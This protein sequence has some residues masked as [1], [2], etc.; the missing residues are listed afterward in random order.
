M[1]VG[2]VQAKNGAPDKLDKRDSPDGPDTVRAASTPTV[3]KATNAAAS[4]VCFGPA[5]RAASSTGKAPAPTPAPAA[6]VAK[7]S[8]TASTQVRPPRKRKSDQ[9]AT[10]TSNAVTTDASASVL[11]D[12]ALGRGAGTTEPAIAA[13]L[14]DSIEVQPSLQQAVPA[15]D[16]VIGHSYKSAA[17]RTGR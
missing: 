14:T 9:V 3:A 11:V 4:S 5:H 6:D 7:A 13:P 12:R 8:A 10:E 16:K 1:P 17:S 15:E 2:P